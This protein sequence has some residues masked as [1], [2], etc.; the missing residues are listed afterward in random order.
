MTKVNEP[1]RKEKQIQRKLNKGP[2]NY[3]RI[4]DI[5]SNVKP[6]DR[7]LSLLTHLVLVPNSPR[8]IFAMVVTT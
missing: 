2:V 5:D 1:V 3:H 8:L 6:E 4:T 7:M